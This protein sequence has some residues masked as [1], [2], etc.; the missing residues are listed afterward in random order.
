MEWKQG[1]AEDIPLEDQ[2]FGLVFMSQVFHHLRQPQRALREVCRV[3]T[4]GGYLIIRNGTEEN[5]E[6]TEWLQ[7]FPEALEIDQ[8]ADFDA[9]RPGGDGLPPAV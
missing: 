6:E 2:S 9:P 1:T 7:C 8:Q 4:L 3:L 5:N